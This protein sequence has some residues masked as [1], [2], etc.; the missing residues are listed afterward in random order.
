M[1]ASSPENKQSRPPYD[2]ALDFFGYVQTVH[3]GNKLTW[4]MGRPDEI[5][6]TLFFTNLNVLRGVLTGRDFALAHRRCAAGLR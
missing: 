4:A 3:L 5:R 1:G 6:S 2:S